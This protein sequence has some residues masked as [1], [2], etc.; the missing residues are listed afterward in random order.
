MNSRIEYVV[1]YRYEHV[2]QVEHI[3][4]LVGSTPIRTIRY[5]YMYMY[6]FIKCAKFPEVA[7]GWL[8]T[9]LTLLACSAASG[10]HQGVA[11]PHRRH[12][13]ISPRVIHTGARRGSLV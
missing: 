7:M 2:Y 6:S 9:S 4:Q 8:S 11:L 3:V 10:L 13:C 5:W 1:L 12:A